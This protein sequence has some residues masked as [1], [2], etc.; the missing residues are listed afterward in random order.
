MTGSATSGSAANNM[1]CRNVIVSRSRPANEEAAEHLLV[2]LAER[3]AMIIH[4]RLE[5]D[6]PQSVEVVLH[7][8]QIPVSDV[9]GI[10]E[11]CWAAFHVEKPH[12]SAKFER[13]LQRI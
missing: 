2:I 10:G 3:D 13:N 12:R 1:G 11:Q 9:A 4:G 7:R 5:H 8:F 6:F